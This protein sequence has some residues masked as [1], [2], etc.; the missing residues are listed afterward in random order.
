LFPRNTATKSRAGSGLHERHGEGLEIRA[1]E[2]E[3]GD[4]H[5]HGGRTEPEPRAP[6]SDAR[7][8]RK[9]GEGRP[10]GTDGILAL[11]MELVGKMQAQL[12]DYKALKTPSDLAKAYDGSFWAKVP[13]ADKKF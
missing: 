3:G 10:G 8:V 11:D 2:Q 5:H 9:T 1:S 13:V 4:R 7:R 6:G 12:I